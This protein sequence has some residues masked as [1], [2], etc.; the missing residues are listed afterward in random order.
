MKNEYERIIV[1]SFIPEDNPGR[2][3]EVHIRPLP[4]QEPYLS[5]YFVQCSKDLSNNYDV[6]TKFR[7]KAK[8]TNRGGGKTFVSSHYTWPYEVLK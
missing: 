2:H 6:G 4:N 5:S 1:E 7:I 3:G 8:L